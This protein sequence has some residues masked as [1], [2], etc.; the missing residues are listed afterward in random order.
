ME[1]LSPETRSHR[2]E[3]LIGIHLVPA[4]VGELAATADQAHGAGEGAQGAGRAGTVEEGLVAAGEFLAA[5]RVLAGD[6]LRLS[7]MMAL[8]TFSS[9]PG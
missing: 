2:G 3:F 7:L 8:K 6:I 1:K 4:A 9:L 5:V